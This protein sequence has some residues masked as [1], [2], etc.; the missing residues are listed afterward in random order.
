MLNNKIDHIT[1]TPIVIAGAGPAGLA[2]AI[3]L[4]QAGCKVIVYEAHKEVGYRF[5]KDFQGLEN[6]T[7][8][9]DVLSIF[10]KSG[11]TT[12]FKHMPCFHGKVYDY[13]NKT[14]QINSEEPIFYMVE[15]GSGSESL[16]T[17]LLNQALSLGVEVRFNTRLTKMTG[18]GILAAGP[19]AADAIAVGYHFETDMENGFWVICDDRLAP[20]GYAYLLVMDGFGTVK[21]CMFRGFKHEKNYVQKTILAFQNLVGLEMKNPKAHGGT[22]NFHIPD[23]AYSGRHPLVGEQ[24]GFQDTMWGFGMRLAISSGL[25]AAQSLL[26]HENY[27]TLWQRELMPQ[28]KTSVVNRT[29]YSMLGNRGYSWFFKKLASRSDIR[30]MLRRQYQPSWYKNLLQPLANVHYRSNRHDKSCDHI[31]CECVWC[32]SKCC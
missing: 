23:N 31:N 32:R 20:K 22:G 6:W 19:K 21:S 5:A 4:A 29:L 12:D 15:R 8:K 28:L 13:K 30:A 2:A 9:E 1:K 24:A 7:T 14:Y 10:T 26:T 11:L 25:L 16:D 3:T 18:Q 27:N 17:A